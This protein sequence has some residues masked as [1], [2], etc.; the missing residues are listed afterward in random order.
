[1]ATLLFKQDIGWH[2]FPADRVQNALASGWLVEEP[3]K[4]PVHTKESDILNFDIVAKK[5]EDDIIRQRAKDV[6]INYWWRKK[7]ETL[8]EELD[9]KEGEKAGISEYKKARITTLKEKLG[10]EQSQ[11]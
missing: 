5:T 2:K 4:E 1:M 8:L 7:P 11:D 6:G 10:Y 9:E 3:A